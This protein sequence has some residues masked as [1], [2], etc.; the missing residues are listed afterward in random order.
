MSAITARMVSQAHA[1]CPTDL[2]HHERMDWMADY[3]S[4]SLDARTSFLEREVQFLRSHRPIARRVTELEAQL[5]LV[6]CGG[7]GNSDET[8]RCLGC[9]HNFKKETANEG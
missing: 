7:C 8:K 6:A 2:P 9:R 4:K 5:G 1:L 3:L